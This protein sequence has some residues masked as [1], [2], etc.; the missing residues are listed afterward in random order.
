G[1]RPTPPRAEAPRRSC[2]LEGGAALLARP[3][4]RLALSVRLAVR[5]TFFAASVPPGSG[6]RS[7]GVTP[8]PVPGRP[9]DASAIERERDRAPLRA[10]TCRCGNE[11]RS[12]QGCRGPTSRRTR[13]AQ[14]DP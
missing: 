10:A 12:R 14:R 13:S 6:D 1:A 4:H 11:D 3:C 7:R 8:G 5:G 9:A 2:P